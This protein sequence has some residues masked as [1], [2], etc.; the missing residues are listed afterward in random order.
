[1]ERVREIKICFNEERGFPT[2]EING[3][4]IQA[5]TKLK[6]DWEARPDKHFKNNFLVEYLDVSSEKPVKILINQFY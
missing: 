2:V 5:I 6:L 3:E 4:R 1:M